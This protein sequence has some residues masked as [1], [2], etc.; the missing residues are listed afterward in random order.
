[1][2]ELPIEIAPEPPLYLLLVIYY[3]YIYLF[4]ATLD[5]TRNAKKLQKSCSWCYKN[6]WHVE[7]NYIIQPPK[8]LVL[9]VN[10]LGLGLGLQ[11]LHSITN[12]TGNILGRF[13]NITGN[14]TRLQCSR[15]KQYTH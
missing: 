13:T 3:T 5:I 8:Y 11:D 14:R 15:Y 6:T 9:I 7:S 4:H 2:L 1:M 12:C 10:R